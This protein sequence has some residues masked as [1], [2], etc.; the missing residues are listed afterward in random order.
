MPLRSLF[1]TCLA[2]GLLAAGAA[3]LSAQPGAP[4]FETQGAVVG[5]TNSKFPHLAV[6]ASTVHLAGNRGGS[7]AS[8]WSKPDIAAV[9][10]AATTIGPAEGQPD[11]STASIAVG[12]GGLLHYVWVNQPS[13][14]IFLRTRSVA[15][16]WGPTRI[17]VSGQSFPVHP[18]LAVTRD[19]AI[20][21]VWR[22][23][24]RP[25]VYRRSLDGGLTWGGVVA[26]SDGP[27]VGAAALA[28]GPGGKLAIAYT[29]GEGDRLQ[30]YLA[31]WDGAHFTTRRV[32]TLSGNYADPSVIYTQDGRLMIAWR[33]VA[34]SGSGSG[35]FVSEGMP[36]GS[37]PVAQLVAGRVGGRVS[38]S[39][40]AAGNLHMLWTGA[41]SGNNQLWYATKLAGAS[42]SQPVA[43]PQAGGEIFNAYGGAAV[44][45]GG[46]A[47]AHA[48][49]ELF[50]G[51]SVSL[52]H[53]RFRGGAAGLPLVGARPL[54]EAGAGA[55]RAAEVRVEL[56]DV[57]GAPTE[58]RLRWGAAPSDAEP[59]LP[60]ASP[61]T[62]A[63]PALEQPDRCGEAAL[64]AQVRGAG[65]IQA[66]ALSDTIVLDRAVQGRALASHQGAAAGYTD[67]PQLELVVVDEGE[68]S[69]LATM[70][71]HRE[72]APYTTLGEQGQV[73]MTIALPD[74]EGAYE[75]AVELADGLGNTR[76][77]T[78]G[79]IYDRTDPTGTYPA[80]LRIVPDDAATILQT[81][82]IVGAAYSD[83]D[84]SL[85]WAAAVA[86]SRGPLSADG[87][88][89]VWAII[90]FE[91]GRVAWA[92]G[93]EAAPTVT[94]A[95]ELNMATM[96]PRAELT[97][98][99]YFYAL[100][101]LDKAGNPTA[102]MAFGQLELAA[103]TYPT[104]YLPAVRR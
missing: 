99:V 55:T 42:W 44:G 68:C 76:V 21:V 38:L 87:E 12:Q 5:A 89:L 100:A 60:I 95:V 63:A 17:V 96:L 39:G 47:Y 1:C 94:G 11:Y 45:T 98:G 91:A 71:E 35:V 57:R 51:K 52:R 92:A 19:G 66:Q 23:P 67:E 28:A 22:N 20:T 70:R 62:V 34:D 65:V 36:D 9:F 29:G 104:V 69:G 73:A 54:I 56:V 13:R 58:V 2:L 74:V 81:A 103:V 15:G 4:A 86:V 43:A 6:D 101:L 49:S 78:V 14:T 53:Y 7:D 30:I 16:V 97:P 25:F 82:T 72:G 83:G 75:R 93:D 40:D 10:D 3:S 77:I 61:L 48:V 27:G 37:Y 32:T 33:G 85:P 84:E 88:G 80:A 41:A 64:F 59:W 90:P 102:A 24:D 31:V 46:V 79:V 18:E 50:T 8:Y 26:L